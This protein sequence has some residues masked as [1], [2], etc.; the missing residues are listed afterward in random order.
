M[1]EI[2]SGKIPWRRTWQPTA[3]F[4]PGKSHGQRSLVGYSPWG[5]KR[6][7]H[8][9]ATNTFR[10][11]I[12]FLVAQLCIWILSEIIPSIFSYL[13]W[14]SY[15]GSLVC[16]IGKDS[17]LVMPVFVK[18]RVCDDQFEK[19][20]P[21]SRWESSRETAH[22]QPWQVLLIPHSILSAYLHLPALR[23]VLGMPSFS[24]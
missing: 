10:G 8:N 6:V 3:V 4:L 16:S 11:F 21:Y 18:S 23:S 15:S 22:Y 9:W 1:Q 13:Q 19:Q 7:G 14:E 17:D 24:S 2:W 20:I 12:I 5:C